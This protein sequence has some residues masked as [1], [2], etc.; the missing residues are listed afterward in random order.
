MTVG[1]LIFAY[2]NEAFEYVRMAAWTAQNIRRHLGIP[3]AVVTDRPTDLDFDRVI[4]HAGESRDSRWFVD[5]NQRAAWHN[6]TRADAYD[7]TP[8]DRTLLIDADYV[9]ASHSLKVVLDLPDQSVLCHRGAWDVTGMNDFHALNHLGKYR[10]P[11][12]WATVVVFNR[13]QHAKMVFDCMRMI[14]DNWNHY[15]QIYHEPSAVYRNDHS[16]TIALNIANGHW[17]EWPVIPWSLATV[18]PEHRVTRVGQDRYRVD[19]RRSDNRPAW[20]EIAGQDFHAMGK[21]SI[22]DM[23][24]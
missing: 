3:V 11:L 1:A 24:A 19:F 22:M 14:R 18:L 4:I 15:R 20:L 2:N 10:W 9:V 8:W 23:L 13:D 16:L 6:Q 17:P 12:C 7:L 5:A 21:R